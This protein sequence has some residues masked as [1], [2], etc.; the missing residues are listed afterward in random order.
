[1]T[2]ISDLSP[3]MLDALQIL[4]ESG[5]IR[6]ADGVHRKTIEALA[7]RGWVFIEWGGGWAFDGRC[8]SVAKATEVGLGVAWFATTIA[9]SDSDG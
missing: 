8:T 5:Q 9:H 6:P 3:H 7:R 2:T 1:M 4:R